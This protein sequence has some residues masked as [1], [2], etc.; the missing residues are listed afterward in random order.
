LFFLV[1]LAHILGFG[2]WQR[3]SQ[4]MLTTI[5]DARTPVTVHWTVVAWNLAIGV[6]LMI[7]L[8]AGHS[9]DA[10]ADLTTATVVREA[11]ALGS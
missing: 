1:P 7:R 8:A 11:P 10:A 9:R 5:G 6:A 4:R 3:E 2:L